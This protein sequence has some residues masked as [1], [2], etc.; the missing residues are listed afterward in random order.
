M[1]PELHISPV[2]GLSRAPAR[3]ILDDLE[4]SGMRS[5]L[6]SPVVLVGLMRFTDFAIAVT[7]GLLMAALYHGEAAIM[8]DPLYLGMIALAGLSTLLA[9]DGLGLYASPSR[10][11][12]HR[13]LPRLMLAWALAFAVVGVF[14]FFLKA[15]H[16]LSRGWLALWF[17]VGGVALVA[18]RAGFS[19]L[20]QSLAESGRLLR[21]AVIYGTG[22]LTDDIIR[23][24]EAD[25]GADIRIVGVF[26]DRQARRE[27]APATSYTRLGTLDDLLDVAR[28]HHVDLVIVA[29]P[30][31]GERRLF[32]VANR[33]SVLPADIRLPAQATQIRLASRLYSHVGQV[34]MIDLYDRPIAD[35][36]VV[37]K[38]LFDKTIGTL[39]LAAL[40]PLM[41]LVALAIKL[42]SRGPVLFRQK[43]YG[44][45][46]ELIEVLKFRSMHVA[47]CDANADRLVTRDDPRVTRVGRFIRRTSLDEL[48][49]L[50]NVLRG[51]LSLVGPRP[52]AIAA[53]AQD[54]LYNEIV[55][56]YFARHKVK[57]GITGWAQICGWRGETDTEEKIAKRVE[58]DLYYIENWS[59]VFD[60]Y[61]LA[62]TPLALLKNENAY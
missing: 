56:R 50:I 57:P 34:A 15:G 23:A 19:L 6:L 46:N 51:E 58:H 16:E 13:T 44:F 8:A 5:A 49:Q 61:I 62:M 12:F 29:L 48:P 60:L 37:L 25:S 24:L 17:A 10:T 53:K 33:L 7:S 31:A 22:T 28:A 14:A 38:W 27:L 1:Q 11:A 4:R 54:R 39:A 35:W 20:L 36:G 18:E 3:P 21:R 32:D 47:L 30:I 59:V 43:R 26:D 2:L 41:M 45:N 9:L 52:H 40:A 42:E 55:A